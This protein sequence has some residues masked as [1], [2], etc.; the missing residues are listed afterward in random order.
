MGAAGG[1]GRAVVALAGGGGREV[2]GAA[3]GGG[4]AVVALPGGGGRGGL[5]APARAGGA[6]AVAGPG[7]G[8]L[9]GAEPVVRSPGA[10]TRGPGAG[11][12][13]PVGR[14]GP[15]SAERV[16]EPGDPG[17]QFGAARGGAVEV[18]AGPGQ[19]ETE[20]GDLL[21]G[22]GGGET[23]G[24]AGL[25]FGGVLLL[26]E[27]DVEPVREGVAGAGPGIVGG[28]RG[29]VQQPGVVRLGGGGRA[30]VPRRVVGEQRLDHVPRGHLTP[31]ETGPHTVGVALPEDTAP[32]DALVETAQQ[33]VQPACEL[34]HP[35]REL[36]DRHSSDSRPDRKHSDR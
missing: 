8:R 21:R 33:P 28:E 31:V 24:E 12:R 7:A 13:S 15:P 34:P 5:R 17:P 4:R 10:P 36:F 26:A 27:H 14:A 20:G 1:G 2:M 19:I 30:A 35:A 22:G 11:C 6:V 32:A 3:G 29:G 16:V 18:V 25:A 23:P 9:P